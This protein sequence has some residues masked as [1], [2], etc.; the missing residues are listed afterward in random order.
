MFIN[1]KI[2]GQ[3]FGEI[4][5]LTNLRRTASIFAL[6]NTLTGFIPKDD[7]NCLMR[8]NKNL[9]INLVENLSNYNDNLIKFF[10]TMVKNVN[11]FRKLSDDSIRAIV[12]LLRDSKASKGN[13]VLRLG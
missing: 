1:E 11:L 10:R 6:K 4:G 13:L 12:F 8:E 9:R 3:Y 2:K 7:F 5:L